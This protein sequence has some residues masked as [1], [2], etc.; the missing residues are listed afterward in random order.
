MVR[1]PKGSGR[2]W[3]SP[4]TTKDPSLSRV[5]AYTAVTSKVAGAGDADGD[6]LLALVEGV[7]VWE[8]ETLAL[9]DDEG[10]GDSD[11]V[12]DVE[13]ESLGDDV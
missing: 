9:A 13:A 4:D 2:G 5:I 7:G 10:E 6:T 8:G 1:T 11:S 12:A 3:F